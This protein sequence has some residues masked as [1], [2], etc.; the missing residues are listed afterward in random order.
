MNNAP[1]GIFDSGSGG[2][3]VWASIHALL[4]SESVVYIGDHSHCPYGD[5]SQS[6]IVKRALVLVEH[7][8]S[9]GCKIIVVACNT[10]TIAAIDVIRKTFPGV[11]IVGAVP[12]VKTAAQTSKTKH[13]AVLSTNFTARSRHQRDLIKKFASDCTVASVGSKDLVRLIEN[14]N[15]DSRQVK[16]EI[17]CALGPAVRKPYDVIILGCTHFPFVTDAVR[18]IVGKGV[19]IIDSGEAVARQVKRVLECDNALS[20]GRESKEIFLT[21]GE[22]KRVEHLF[23]QLLRWDVEVS[24]VEL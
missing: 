5:K 1:I 13:F 19:G 11:P 8:I 9:S 2:L 22:A 18:D 4:P 16:D 21:T 6:W 20:S 15:I 23:Q 14:G 3:S 7:L 10:I 17:R 24:H 12:V